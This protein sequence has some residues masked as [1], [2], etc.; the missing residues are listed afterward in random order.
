MEVKIEWFENKNMR[1]GKFTFSD[2]LTSLSAEEAVVDW[3]ERFAKQPH[4]KF[5]L[6]WD[7]SELEDYDSACQEL[8]QEA[9]QET[10]QQV[11]RIW[12]ISNSEIVNAE[13]QLR[14]LFDDF[15]V[16]MASLGNNI[17]EIT[18]H[19]LSKSTLTV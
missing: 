12:I 4:E 8:W 18:K 15:N 19:A 3:K 5:T 9:F 1:Y 16:K 7:C 17:Y 14:A 6:V 10:H 2:K 13:V 11:E